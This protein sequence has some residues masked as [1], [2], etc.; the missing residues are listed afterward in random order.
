MILALDTNVLAYA[1]GVGDADR[2]AAA[3]DLLDRLQRGNVVLPVQVLG[4]LF[5]VLVR[6]GRRSRSEA[7]DA[8]LAWKD[9]F[10]LLPTTGAALLAASDLCVDHELSMWDALILG[11]AAEA[12][13]RLLV[14]E[15][16]QD[17]F[18]WHGVTVV[19]PFAAQRHELLQAA[20]GE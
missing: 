2:H 13:C 8:V 6:K 10:E 18:T 7:R 15:D 17:G 19:D 9:A 4:E 3:V 5:A 11:V 1:E 12:G 20:L 16:L 14:T